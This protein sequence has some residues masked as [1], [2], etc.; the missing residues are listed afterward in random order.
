VPDVAETIRRAFAAAGALHERVARE[1]ATDIAHLAALL[2]ATL[3]DRRQ[4]LVFGN[5]GS[6]T[7]AQHFAAELV[8]RFRR[9][10][11]AAPVVALT[12]DSAILTSVANDCGYDEVF[13]RQIEGLG[14]PGDVA[15]GITTSG[16][17]G[18]VNLALARARQAGLTTAALTGRNGGDT[19]PLA[20][21]H[22][23]VPSD[24]T[25]RVQE[26]Q[27]TILHIVCELIEEGL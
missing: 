16:R 22:V 2:R 9:D 24:D 3:V 17:S 1:R 21:V 23:N 19:G 5:G 25:P 8:G 4:V 15:F 6:A 10:R 12:A 26:V 7:D 27:R 18:N 13:A 20:D 14:R 11:R